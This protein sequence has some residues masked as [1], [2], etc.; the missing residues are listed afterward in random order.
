MERL[1]DF[2]FRTECEPYN[3]IQCSAIRNL[4][5]ST[6][7]FFMPADSVASSRDEALQSNFSF[8]MGMNAERRGSK[9]DL[10]TSSYDY[11][12]SHAKQRQDSQW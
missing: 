2:V 12:A 9:S 8:Q 4:T 3:T 6:V 11:G 5:L 1:F 7:F 10:S